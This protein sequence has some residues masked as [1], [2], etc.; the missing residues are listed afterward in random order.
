MR[1]RKAAARVLTGLPFWCWCVSRTTLDLIQLILTSVSVQF[2][3]LLRCRTFYE[4]ECS[5]LWLSVD[6]LV[7]NWSSKGDQT[8]PASQGIS[9]GYKTT[10]AM[11]FCFLEPFCAPWLPPRF[12]VG[13]CL[14]DG[15]GTCTPGTPATTP[16]TPQEG[17]TESPP[18]WV[19]P[20]NSETCTRRPFS[21]LAFSWCSLQF[22]FPTYS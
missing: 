13:Y 18:E 2:N 4:Q 21:V 6:G 19:S 20:G 1:Q 14:I 3:W 11:F 16:A 22:W 7:G 12:K 15:S 8:T 17:E 10:W 5:T 9:G